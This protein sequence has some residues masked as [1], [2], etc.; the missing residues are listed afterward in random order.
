MM[1]SKKSN[2]MKVTIWTDTL[3]SDMVGTI[4]ASVIESFG[5]IMPSNGKTAAEMRELALKLMQERH[6]QLKASGQ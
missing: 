2:E 1:A 4:S 3:K 5:Y 6:E